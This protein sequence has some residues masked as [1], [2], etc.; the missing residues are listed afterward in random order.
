LLLEERNDHR[1]VDRQDTL[2]LGR[3]LPIDRARMACKRLL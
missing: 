3:A 1:A 2:G